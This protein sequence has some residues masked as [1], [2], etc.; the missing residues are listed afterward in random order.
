MSERITRLYNDKKRDNIR[1][2]VGENF[3]TTVQ[4]AMKGVP[5]LITA[6][7]AVRCSR[8]GRLGYNA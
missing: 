1:F 8:G 2:C 7:V 5:R 4:F 3:V 6:F